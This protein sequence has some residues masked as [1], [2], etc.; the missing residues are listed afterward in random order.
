MPPEVG[1]REGV[2][3]LDDACEVPEAVGAEREHAVHLGLVGRTVAP[4]TLVV[5]LW[6]W[7]SMMIQQMKAPLEGL[8]NKYGQLASCIEPSWLV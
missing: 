3:A 7:P 5:L 4:T 8:G 1:P 2:L 6:G